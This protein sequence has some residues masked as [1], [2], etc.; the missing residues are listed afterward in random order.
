MPI[1][2][3][4][5]PFQLMQETVSSSGFAFDF[6]IAVAFSRALVEV[7]VWSTTKAGTKTIKFAG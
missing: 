1:A 4:A 3:Y 6:A 5:Y 2:S 7:W